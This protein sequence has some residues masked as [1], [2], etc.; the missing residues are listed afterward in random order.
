[1]NWYK[2]V[3]IIC[4][5]LAKKYSLQ[6]NQIAGII[7]T[8]SAQKN[9]KLNI[10]QTIEFLKGKKLTGMYS[11]TQFNN[12][13]RIINGENPLNIW[14]KTSFKYR[15]FYLSILGCEKACCIDTHMINWYLNKYQNSKLHRVKKETIFANKAN[16]S[17]I[18][19][20]V[21]KEAK[22][23]NLIPSHMQAIIWVQQR[24]GIM[25]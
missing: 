18:Q 15:N 24:N 22:Q 12:C 5:K 25:F 13:K 17:L 16:Y 10:R 11:G 2:I 6:V 14:G 23:N 20:A 8:L 19:K 4:H 3:N 21:I 7:V 9:W 1:M